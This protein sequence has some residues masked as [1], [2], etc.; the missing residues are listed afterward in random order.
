MPPPHPPTPPAAASSAVTRRLFLFLMSALYLA[1][2]ASFFN[3]SPG[4]V[5]FDGL[6]PGSP[7]SSGLLAWLCAALGLHVD[8]G[9]DLVSLAGLALSLV[10]LTGRATTAVMFS[11]YLL[12][13]AVY[14]HG[15]TFLGFQWDIL[16]LEAGL[17]AAWYASPFA[18]TST[19]IDKGRGTRRSD[20][21]SAASATASGGG[22]GG[23]DSASSSRRGVDSGDTSGVSRGFT[24][25]RSFNRSGVN[26][27]AGTNRNAGFERSSPR[28]R[29]SSSPNAAE[30]SPS[31]TWALRFLLF[32]LMLMSG[33]VKIQSNDVAWTQLTALHYHYAT[34]CIPTPLAWYGAQLASPL[35]KVRGTQY[36]GYDGYGGY[37][38]YDGYDLKRARA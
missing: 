6:L 11:L 15:G 21:R 28:T 35:L 23:G 19:G 29:S 4:L 20:T 17:L 2:F 34:Q 16:L 26:R 7:G 14:S 8:A 31:A 33:V 10:A 36:D 30:P 3:Q 37:G 24:T 18:R 22:V 12:Y 13:Y 5:G 25:P 9:I 1:A 32:K 27:N 38:G